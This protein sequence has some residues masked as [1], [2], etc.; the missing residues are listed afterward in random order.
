MDIYA[1]IGNPVAHSKS[2]F[3]H[4]RFAQ[5]TGRTM[6]YTTLLAPLDGFEQAVLNFRET[7]GKGMNITVPFKFEAYTLATR[8]TDRARAARAVNTFRF[9]ENKEMLGDNTDGIGLVRDIEVNLNF[10]LKDKH[11]L[12][13][14]AGG[15]ASGIILPLLQQQPSL[16]AVANRTPDKA[17][18]LQQRFAHHGNI[19]GGHYQHFIG[20]HFD[21]VINATSASLHNECPP[22]PPDLFHGTALAYDLLYSS[23]LTPFLEFASTQGVVHLADGAGM[24]VEQAAESF[25]LWHGIRPETQLVISQLRDELRHHAS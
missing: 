5:Q 11:I 16:L 22:I 1:V 3:I 23:T 12:L 18:A 17:T 25:L 8:L 14:G 15:A 10:S 21:L 19:I 9:E 6:R 4:T 13:M 7:G 24:L 2:P 20:Q